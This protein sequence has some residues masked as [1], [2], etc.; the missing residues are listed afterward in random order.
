MGYL[1]KFNEL[2]DSED[3]KSEFEIPYLIGEL[4]SG[5]GKWKKVSK[6]SLVETPDTFNKKIVFRYP[7]LRHF[8]EDMFTL[9]DGSNVYCNYASGGEAKDGNAY[10][11]QI[12]TSYNEGDYF[13]DVIMRGINDYD[14]MSKWFRQDFTFDNMDSVYVVVEAFLKS[15]ADL[16]IISPRQKNA[17]DAN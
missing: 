10:Y 12:T 17:L 14:D 16:N 5:I 8:N 7:I 6:P 4:P 13:I 9:P 15:C 3:L 2:F 11:A 1:K